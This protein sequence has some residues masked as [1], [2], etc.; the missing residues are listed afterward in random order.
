MDTLSFRTQHA[1]KSTVKQAWWL[2]D[3]EGQT[4][5]R[6]STKIASLL[7]GKHKPYFTTHVDC[8]DHVVVINAEKVRMTGK[9]MSDKIIVTYTGYPGGKRET[10]PEKLLDKKP[11]YLIEEAIRGMLPKTRLG[12]AMFGKLHVFA[13]TRHNHMAQKPTPIQNNS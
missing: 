1:N 8:G 12:R 5:G 9:K 6:L 11:E 13:G 2:V 7:I 3:A 10:T 4:L